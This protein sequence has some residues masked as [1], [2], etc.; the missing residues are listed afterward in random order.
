[1]GWPRDPE[2]PFDLPR[3]GAGEVP[4]DVRAMLDRAQ[5][6]VRRATQMQVPSAKDA[7]GAG[8]DAL[9]SLARRSRDPELD[10]LVQAVRRGDVSRD[11]ALR[12]PAYLRNARQA[13]RDLMGEVAADPSVGEQ[14]RER[15]AGAYEEYRADPEGYGSDEEPTAG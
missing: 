9:V 6:M 12:H 11:E 5:Q 14:L 1:M 10:E 15:W 3:S 8:Q 13:V 2:T 7:P 4:A